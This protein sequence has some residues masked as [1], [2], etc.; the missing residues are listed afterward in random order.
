MNRK[1]FKKLCLSRPVFLDG[2]T[3]TELIKRGM[4][5]GVCPEL[6][7]F[8]NP[9]SII[10]IQKA[11]R[12][13]GSDI[14]YVPTFGGNSLKLDEFGLKDRLY[15]LNKGLCQLSREAV[16]DGMVFGDLAPTGELIE[17]FGPLKFDRCVEIY[18]EQAEA[19][20]DGGVDGFVIETMMDIQEARAALLGI[21]EVAPDYPVMVSMTYESE[22]RTLT[23]TDPLTALITLQS[24]G[25]DAVGCNCS[26]GPEKMVEWVAA[27]KPCA[28]VPL[29]AK[30]NA[31]Q[32]KL[33]AGK[34]VF[35]MP[36][37]EYAG[38]F[39]S[40]INAGANL[41]G[42]C[43][44]STPEHIKHVRQ[45]T[46]DI[47]P[48]GIQHD[49]ITAVS[50]VR[51]VI[52]FGHDKPFTV[53]GERINPTGKKK[54]QED[55][56]AGKLNLARTYAIEQ[57]KAGASLL[58][59]NMGLSGINEKEM[60][61]NAVS[62][63][64]QLSSCPLCID[65]TDPDVIEAALRIYPG[66][67][68][69][70]SI[71][72]EKERIEKMLP[73]AHKY[74]AIFILLPVTDDG[75]AETLQEKKEVTLKI[76]QKAAE[77]NLTAEDCIIDGLV[78]T[79]SSSP[80]APLVTA[81]FI[82]W[83]SS[84]LKGNTTG[85]ISNVSFGMPERIRLNSTF[86]ALLIGK[87][88]TSAIINPSSEEMM[89][90]KYSSDALF[91]RDKNLKNYLG[92]YTAT[93]SSSAAAAKTG[94][95]T[96][97]LKKCFN[98]VLYGEEDNIIDVIS[99]ARSSDIPAKQIVDEALIPAII[100]VGD[101]YD[102]KEYFLPQLML[103]AQTMSK[104]FQQLESELTQKSTTIKD[105]I[106]MATVKGDIHDIGKNIVSLML[107]NYGFDVIDLGKDVDAETIISTAI[108]NNVSL[109]G[110]SA[111]MTTTMPEMKKVIDF[112]REK[113]MENL[114]F[115]IGGAVVDKEYAVEIG[116]AGYAA[117]A[118][119]AVRIAQKLS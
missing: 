26:A 21:R 63:L 96:D 94:A 93:T 19:L 39:I 61:L 97:P 62:M 87:G 41:I 115:I 119:E 5:S 73:L 25:A 45:L 47:R 103:S 55:L 1:E 51:K 31:G 17:P 71:S 106:I 117:D 58:D 11:Y 50:S 30:P 88:L 110:L 3:G 40:L 6:W 113:N 74:G 52:E 60:M 114:K 70:N 89:A 24:L 23:G 85:G 32:P 43:C 112:A 86:L 44:G 36:P 76:L 79:V 72:L 107:S 82:E 35:D 102:K 56:R 34:T 46:A 28:T 111:L 91:K 16:G 7:V 109:I 83:C 116:A 14:V 77:Y 48:V 98:A 9:D 12:K 78:M 57:E 13:A 64:S 118:V 66:R 4:P 80:E 108:Q 69:L 54:L 84:E 15:E 100:A 8:D 53:I 95:E 49:K 90:V 18:R 10:Q 20:L 33:I 104:G 92:K 65:S 59:V 101:R 68:L 67:A 29:L 81:E 22:G 99:A 75:V 42:G 38:N 105:K 27:M 2:A 37:E